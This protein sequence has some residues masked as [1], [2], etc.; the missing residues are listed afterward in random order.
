MIPN[1]FISATIP[2]N[3]LY[4]DNIDETKR[5][6]KTHVSRQFKN[7]LFDRDT[8][9]ITHYDVNFLYVVSLY[10]RNNAIQKKN[11][12]LKV[13]EIFRD[14]IRDELARRYHFYAMR[15]KPSVNTK[16]YFE[17]HFRDVL[18]KVFAPYDDKGIIA[19]A[20][21]NRKEFKEENQNLI[22]QLE[23]S[24]EIRE[25]N[26]GEDPRPK[27]PASAVSFSGVKLSKRGVLMVM[28]EDYAKRSEKSF[29]KS[30]KIA[31]GIKYHVRG[32][33]IINNL[34]NIGYVLFHTW[35]KSSQ[36][37]FAL[38]GD[39]QIVAKM[40]FQ[41]NTICHQRI[42]LILMALLMRHSFSMFCLPQI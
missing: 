21:D 13:R 24:F 12:K 41:M 4:T 5:S 37:M 39:C 28:M 29:A 7:R 10:A 35:D 32:M 27:L 2:D 14:K 36:K 26:L 23:K 33:E 25:C 9:L 20:L 38:E 34:A 31:V 3:L 1:F 30:G 19:L 8:L 6:A 11:W 16:E 40:R 42:L 17:A 18:G 15:A 22:S